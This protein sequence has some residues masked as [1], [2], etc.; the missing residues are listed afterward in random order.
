MSS[1]GFR[2][3]I[4]TPELLETREPGW[5]Y[6][7]ARLS[8][9]TFLDTRV[10]AVRVAD[11]EIAKVSDNVFT[12]PEIEALPQARAARGYASAD[13]FT[14]AL[15]F[16]FDPET[17]AFAWEISDDN[18]CVV[19]SGAGVSGGRGTRAWYSAV[20]ALKWHGMEYAESLYCLDS[21]GRQP[22]TVGAEVFLPVRRTTTT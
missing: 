13:G 12:F 2:K 14:L 20:S 21:Y 22:D 17:G 11:G 16:V 1:T 7:A 9:G 10:Y 15:E 4:L 6:V 18:Q 8:E 3:I 19:S 5:R